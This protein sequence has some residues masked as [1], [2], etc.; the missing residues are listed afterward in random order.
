MDQDDRIRMR[1]AVARGAALLDEYVSD[2][3]QIIDT[4]ML[5][6]QSCQRCVAGQ[7]MIVASW[8]GE[9]EVPGSMQ[10]FAGE[11]G[12]DIAGEADYDVL[13]DDGYLYPNFDKDEA[14]AALEEEWLRVINERKE[15]E[16][17]MLNER[18]LV[19]A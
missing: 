5:E 1:N 7:V 12:F 9:M 3:Y 6:M 19:T 2:W 4:R 8:R 16:T 14:W 11:C 10:A 13:D 15:I 18:E 17:S